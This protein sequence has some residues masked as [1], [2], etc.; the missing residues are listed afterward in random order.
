MLTFVQ[1]E[2]YFTHILN[3]AHEHRQFM[4]VVIQ[5]LLSSS[6]YKQIHAWVRLFVAGCTPYLT[7]DNYLARI[8][9]TFTPSVIQ[10]TSQDNPC[11]V[12]NTLGLGPY[13]LSSFVI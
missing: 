4:E 2:W 6:E 9:P 1:P 12:T 7:S 3:V 11:S 8:C 13:D 10:K 5:P